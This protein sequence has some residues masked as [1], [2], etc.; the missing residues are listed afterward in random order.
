MTTLDPEL[1]EVLWACYDYWKNM[2]YPEERRAICYAWVAPKYELRFKVR[3]QESKLSELAKRG[4]LEL[5]EF[6]GGGNRRYYRLV[7]PER[8]RRLLQEL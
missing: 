8:I 4:L 3:F 2:E 5:D 1:K 7:D 6:S